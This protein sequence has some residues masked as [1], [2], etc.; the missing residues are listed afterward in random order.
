MPE[1][2]VYDET[3][4]GLD[5][6]IDEFIEKA[7][8]RDSVREAILVGTQAVKKAIAN[9]GDDFKEYYGEDAQL[10][11]CFNAAFDHLKKLATEG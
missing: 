6:F 9:P 1:F 4:E 8:D 10:D 2:L 7:L 11:I 3:P 5:A